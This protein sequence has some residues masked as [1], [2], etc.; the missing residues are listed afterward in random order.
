MKNHFPFSLVAAESCIFFMLFFISGST[1]SQLIPVSLDQRITNAQIIFEGKVI[2]QNSF[3]DNNHANIYTSNIVEVYK[4]FKGNLAATQVEIVTEGGIVGTEK[5]VVSHTLELNVGDAGIFTGIPN[6]IKSPQ[7]SNLMSLK[8]YADMQ[9][10]I[11]YDLK[12]N[13][14]HD[15]FNTYTNIMA[16]VYPAITKRTKQD[17]KEIQKNN[18]NI[19]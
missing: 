14:A 2:S 18:F 15:V 12:T 9:G 6:T 13:S 11:R 8:T 7:K 17:I 19:K 4:V 3:W 10:F 5:E 1:F 16:D